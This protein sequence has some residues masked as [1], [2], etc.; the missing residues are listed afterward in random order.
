MPTSASR[1]ANPKKPNTDSDG[2]RHRIGRYSNGIARMTV[3]TVV[4]T[5]KNGAVS[6]ADDQ[7]GLPCAMTNAVC[8][9][10]PEMC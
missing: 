4:V 1:R 8:V 3:A 10:V 7:A 5:P 2:V 6:S 9:I